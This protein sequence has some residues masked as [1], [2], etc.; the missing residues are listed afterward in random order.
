MG[1]DPKHVG[2]YAF[3]HRAAGVSTP[4]ASVYGS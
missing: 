1:S 3:R 4:D 2:Q